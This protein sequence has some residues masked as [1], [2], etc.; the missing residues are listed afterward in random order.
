MRS[1]FT[2]P[3]RL[4]AACAVAGAASLLSGNCSGQTLVAAD[5]ATNSAYNSG[6]AAGQNGGY[7]FGPWSFDGTDPTPAGQYQGMS[8]A[9]ALG[10]TW[11]L[12]THD[13]SSGL[14]N[15][16]RAIPG[17]LQPGQTFESVL[18]NPQTWQGV[19]SYRGFDLLFTSNDNNDVG[20]DNTSAL[21]LTVFD[22]FNPSQNWTVTDGNGTA[23]PT[24]DAHTTAAAGMKLD[25]TL[26]STSTY[27]LTLTPL[28]DPSMSY[29][30]AGTFTANVPITWFNFR[31]WNGISAGLNDYSNNFS[32]SS[33]TISPLVLNIQRA[34]PNVLLSWPAIQSNFILVSTPTLDPPVWTPVSTA[35][36]GYVNDEFVVTNA[37]TGSQQ[38]YRLVLQ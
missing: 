2:L 31:N 11:S 9:S 32:I 36:S 30:Q 15:A 37:I 17:G 38:F 35:Q 7:G 21:R 29:T 19:Y 27:S 10:T 3:P 18:Q 25:L 23:H 12:L 13:S 28:S 8:T 26:L 16:G 14:A 33:M 24:L 5:Y 22:Y 4:T 20:G 1:H 34:G 6:W